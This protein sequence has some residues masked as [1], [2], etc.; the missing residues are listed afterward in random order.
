MKTQEPQDSNGINP[1]APGRRR[2][3]KAIGLS[4]VATQ[5]GL[6]WT[7]PTIRLGSLP[8]HAQL[9]EL[10]C[11][12]GFSMTV[13][14]SGLGSVTIDF[15]DMATVTAVQTFSGA[16]GLGPGEAM[17][18]TIDIDFSRSASSQFGVTW[19]AECCTETASGQQTVGG[20]LLVDEA[21]FVVVEA[22]ASG[23][24]QLSAPDLDDE[25]SGLTL[26]A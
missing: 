20:A 4:A 14:P 18:G 8:A 16:A 5:I 13:D 23:E 15:I 17:G 6:D 7:R 21:Q 9:T 25:S 1:A 11:T 19:S 22:T 12:V 26:F 2:L 24:C 3:L 10:W